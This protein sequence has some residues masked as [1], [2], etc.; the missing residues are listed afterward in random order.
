MP[1]RVTIDNA[2]CAITRAC[3]RD[4]EVQR[5]YAELAEGYGFKIDPCP[6]R[7]PQKKGRVESGIKYVKRNF[8]PLREFRNLSDGNGQLEAWVLGRAGNRIH[9][10]TRERPLTRFAETERD[11]LQTL[12]AA[13]P[14]PSTWAR[15]IVPADHHVRLEHGRYSVPYTLIGERLWLRATPTAVQVYEEYTM[16]AA[17]P[18]MRPGKRST[19]DDHLP[20]EALAHKRRTPDWC[21]S[22]A[23]SIGP[24][25]QGLIDALFADRV[26]DNLRAAQGV[27]RLAERYGEDR[28]EAACERALAFENPRYR[29]VKTILERGLDQ[30]CV[31]PPES[32][33]LAASY[34]GSGRFCR[35]TR[36]LLAH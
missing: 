34:T 12:P 32:V 27:I 9:G 30:H 5:S 29:C 19:V 10:S 25:C 7:D 18:R 17:H 31:E 6:P 8:L 28:L 36:N 2:K 20:P 4:P 24:S 11:L 33:Q 1:L 35:D 13:A 21:R 16:V 15:A 3:W 14:E 23:E 26:L 22:Q